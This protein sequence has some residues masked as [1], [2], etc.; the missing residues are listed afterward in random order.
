MKQKI[1]GM[2]VFIIT[3]FMVRAYSASES[4]DS[5]AL[6]NGSFIKG[7]ITELSLSGDVK[8]ETRYGSVF[9]FSMADVKKIVVYVGSVTFHSGSLIKDRVIEITPGENIR[10]DV[11]DGTSLVFDAADVSGI[12]LGDRPNKTSGNIQEE[13][14][15]EKEEPKQEKFEAPAHPVVSNIEA[16]QPRDTF[17]HLPS[18]GFFLGVDGTVLMMRG[19][20][21]I[22]DFNLDVTTKLFDDSE[23][24]IGLGWPNKLLFGIR[25]IVGYKFS[26]R[27]AAEGSFNIL[28]KKAADET[29]TYFNG[30]SEY[31]QKTV[32]LLGK[33]YPLSQQGFFV[34]AGAEITFINYEETFT[35]N[36]NDI[37]SS[38]FKWV[39]GGNDNVFGLAFGCGFE[40]PL[41]VQN[42]T[43]QATALYSLSKYSGRKLLI[44]DEDESYLGKK[45]T[46]QGAAD[47]T[48]M[49]LGIGGLSISAGLRMYLSGKMPVQPATPAVIKD[50]S[51]PFEP[52]SIKEN[53]FGIGLGI[54]YG[55]LGANADINAM[56]NF[57]F[58]LGLGY[59]LLD[60]IGWNVGC[61][62]FFIPPGKSFRPRV[63]LSYGINT[64]IES[65]YIGGGG[66]SSVDSYSGLNL[67]LGFQLMWGSSQSSGIDFD[68]VYILTSSYSTEDLGGAEEPGKL[69][70][71]IGYRHAF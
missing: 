44:F 66:N 51:E 31:S 11:G 61:K 63:S 34:S 22:D 13:P 28:F 3:V 60:G 35:I 69:K 25:P 42:M 14:E 24:N 62:Y 16:Y 26:T 54:P 45:S 65:I 48:K 39:R 38:D 37:F 49:E 50:D 4:Y 56:P 6:K 18:S 68:I 53:S 19:T 17:P 57:Y 64:I 41:G 36:D 67:G 71:S 12:L 20:G 40:M 30:S 2:A 32:Q 23:N 10:S 29:D 21:K 8:I 1:I 52:G 59:T 46:V 9:T 43:L 5:V 7:S 47:D 27:F 15:Q 33:Y 70:F 55:I 58:S